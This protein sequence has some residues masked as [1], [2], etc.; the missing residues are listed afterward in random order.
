MFRHAAVGQL[1][2]PASEGLL[3]GLDQ[4]L[5]RL[6]EN[7]LHQ[8]VRGVVATRSL[9]RKNVRPHRDPAAAVA[10]HLVFEEPLVDRAELL[11]AQAPVVD[12]LFSLRDA[13]ERKRI[14]HP[15]HGRIGDA[16]IRQHPRTRRI[17]Q[18]TVVRR[19]S[20]RGIAEIDRDEQVA[21][22]APVTRGGVREDVAPIHA[23]SDLD[24][25]LPQAVIVVSGLPDRQKI[26]VLG[27]EDEE[28]AIEQDQ[29][30]VPH[31]AQVRVRSG[32]DDG[33]RKVWKD[34]SKHLVRQ[35][36][37]DA[38]FVEPALFNRLL[39]KAARVGS[40]RCEGVA[41]EDQQEDLQPVPAL[42]CTER[43]EPLIVAGKIED[44]RKVNLEELLR[45]RS[46]A[47][48]IEPP[49]L[50]IGEDPPPQ[51]AFGHIVDAA[52]NTHLR[53]HVSKLMFCLLMLLQCSFVSP[54]SSLQNGWTPC[55]FSGQ[56]RNVKW[57]GALALASW[58]QYR[59]APSPGHRRSRLE[60]SRRFGRSV[61][62]FLV[63]DIQVRH[64]PG[65]RYTSPSQPN[66]RPGHS[67]S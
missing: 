5:Q 3:A 55:D 38:P 58:A 16:D 33:A 39:V 10:D 24:T 64:L 54:Q 47:R 28:Q 60:E 36:L 61:A 1:V 59:C 17:E 43:E 34:L 2:D 31:L 11:N 50:T 6:G 21:Q 32:L 52:Q 46:R 45:D 37:G 4:R 56:S 9:A 63:P 51:L 12:V 7:Q 15:G 19:Q 18:A 20:D 62:C 49:F 23:V 22:P 57:H 14:D 65:R 53:G 8:V 13:L 26:A 29:R 42:L 30:P 27:I 44:C 48:E 41:A 40:P 67:P 35:V 25:H 66:D